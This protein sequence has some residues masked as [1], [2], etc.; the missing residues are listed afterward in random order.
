MFEKR[1]AKKVV[2]AIS[3]VCREILREPLSQD[4]EAR[5]LRALHR[6][7]GFVSQG[8]LYRN[9]QGVLRAWRGMQEAARGMRDNTL[10]LLSIPVGLEVVDGGKSPPRGEEE[11]K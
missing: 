4:Q 8:G 7:P 2:E 3:I 9:S 6:N 5:L 1:K 10:A 11:G